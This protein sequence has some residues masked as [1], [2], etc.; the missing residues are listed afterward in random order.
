MGTY[1]YIFGPI[2][3][4]RLGRS[5]GID[6][7]PVKV[8]SEDCVFCQIG[9]TT[10]KTLERKEWVPLGDVLAEF[11]AWRQ[12][13]V[14]CD[15][16]TLSGNGEPTLHTGFGDVLRAARAA[17]YPTALLSN[18]SMMWDPD[19]RRD[20]ALAD[21]VKVTV[22]AWDAPSFDRLHRPAPGLG[23]DRLMS[24]IAAFRR[25]FHGRL[26]VETMILPGFNDR[27]EDI[28]KIAACIRPLRPDAI[29][30][31]TATRPSRSADG[32]LAP[33]DAA[34]LHAAAAFFEPVAEVPQFHGRIR[35][36]SAMDDHEIVELIARHPLPLDAIAAA[37]GEPADAIAR[38]L[39]PIRDIEVADGVALVRDVAASE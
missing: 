6:L 28:R 37:T 29:H 9:R 15:F 13:G 27:E 23:F 11:A 12:E 7:D 1:K 8:C 26:W 10:E 39:A 30:L 34:W 20:A 31:N 14:A 19:V 33:E 16:V 4:R 17:G 38:R 25:E 3:S 18:G 36:F 35:P 24:G 32:P 22:S 2:P 5:L 21:V